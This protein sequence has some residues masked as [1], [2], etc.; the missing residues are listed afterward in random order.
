MQHL[1]DLVLEQIKRKP[2]E[3]AEQAHRDYVVLLHPDDHDF[4]RG[5]VWQLAKERTNKDQHKRLW[6]H[7]FECGCSP[8]IPLGNPRLLTKEDAIG[9]IGEF[10]EE[11]AGIS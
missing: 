8:A 9:V 4:M 5:M 1:A 7:G 11:V 2:L 6:V 3:S 10:A